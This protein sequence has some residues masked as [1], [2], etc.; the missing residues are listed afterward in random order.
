[1]GGSEAAEAGRERRHARRSVLK[2]ALSAGIGLSWIGDAIA[3][4]RAMAQETDPRIARPREGDRLVF[5]TGERAGQVIRPDDVPLGGPIV[6]AFPLDPRTSVI[7]DGSRLNQIVLIHLGAAELAPETLARAADG[8]VAYSAVCTH[9]G[10]DVSLWRAEAKTLR[11]PCHESD[12]DPRD[13]ARVIGG[14]APRRLPSLPVKV[15]DG[16]LVAAGRFSSRVGFQ[17]G[18]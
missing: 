13:G 4:R 5:T 6:I 16:I 2:T 11:C 3:E 18:G 10:C 7:R 15:M 12:F 8:I 1:V 9:A 14:P 17:G